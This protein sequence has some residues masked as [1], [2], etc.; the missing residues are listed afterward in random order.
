MFKLEEFNVRADNSVLFEG[1]ESYANQEEQIEAQ[2]TGI[3]VKGIVKDMFED[4]KVELGMRIPTTFNGSEFFAVV[5][6]RRKRIDKRYALYR[7]TEKNRSYC[8]KK[9][10]ECKN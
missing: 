2:Q 1:L 8:R 10:A 7:K 3:L 6:D 5:D 4:W 9:L